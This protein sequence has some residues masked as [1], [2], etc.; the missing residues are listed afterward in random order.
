MKI[1]VIKD[2]GFYMEFILKDA[3]PAFANSW[4]RA[5]KSHVPT[6]AVDYVD[7]Y[8]NSSY[9]YDEIL[10]HRIGL[11]PLS[12]DLDKFN[13]QD[14]CVCN[15]EGCPNCQVSLRLNVEGPK[16]V[17]SGD[18]ISDDP[19]TKPVFENIPIVELY[20]G[21]QLMIEAVARLGF[22]KEHAKFQPVSMCIYRILANVVIEDSCTNCKKCIEICPKKVFGEKN[23]KVVVNDEFS[24]TMCMDCVSVCE[25]N[26]IR[27]EETSDYV[28]SVESVG[29]MKVREIAKRALLAIK[30]KSQEMNKL[31]EE[32]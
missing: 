15:G 9:L 2:D 25:E 20:E 17:Y 10:A 4:R 24:C 23:G 12:T 29:Q 5:M 19:E 1:E 11:I 21:Q 16:V 13:F 22:G 28:F 26:A 32:L 8:M 3:N 30:E 18:L 27:I 6:L 31:L 14:E 7:F